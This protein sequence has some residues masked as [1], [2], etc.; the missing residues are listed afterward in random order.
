[1]KEII[2]G[3][4]SVIDT[5]LVQAAQTYARAHSDDMTYNHIMRS[6]LLGVII[7]NNIISRSSNV[8]VNGSSTIASMIEMPQSFDIEAHAIS[9]TLHDLGWDNTGEL[10]SVDKRFEVDGANA[11]RTWLQDQDTAKDWDEGRL[12]LVWDSIALHSTPTLHQ[13][14]QA[15]VALAGIGIV[16]DFQGPDSDASGTLSW[17]QFYAVKDLY[18]TLDMA[19]GIHEIMTGFCM[20][21]PD[22]TYG[23]LQCEVGQSEKS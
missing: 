14:K 10:I 12:Q 15:E 7:Y 17:E 21:K 16:S 19:D 11:A 4:V 20:S 6:W 9:A 18:P 3:V 8:T 23:E 2:P 13:H 5:P 1:M 22:V